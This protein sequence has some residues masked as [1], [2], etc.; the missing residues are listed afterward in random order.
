MTIMAIVSSV[1][2]V[3]TLAKKPP[4]TPTAAMPD[5]AGTDVDAK[6]ETG[7][8]VLLGGSRPRDK[9]D[10]TIAAPTKT[11]KKGGSSISGAKSTGISIL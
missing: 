3:A 1:S 5:I 4:K 11:T 8:D 9:A 2:T 7:A 6:A 10:P